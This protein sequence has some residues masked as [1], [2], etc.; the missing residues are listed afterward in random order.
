MAFRRGGDGG[1]A[2]VQGAAVVAPEGGGDA[3]LTGKCW[4]VPTHNIPSYRPYDDSHKHLPGTMSPPSR[5]VGP[6]A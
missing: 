4:T 6:E 2:H 1:D 3:L 5:P